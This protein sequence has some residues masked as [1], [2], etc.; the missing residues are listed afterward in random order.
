M[1]FKTITLCAL[2][3]LSF[4]PAA[5]SDRPYAYW[6]DEP[7]WT[8]ERTEAREGIKTAWAYLTSMRNNCWYFIL[9]SVIVDSIIMDPRLVDGG[10]MH[11]IEYFRD[12]YQTYDYYYRDAN[13]STI[14][15][16]E[17]VSANNKQPYSLNEYHYIAS[18]GLI[19]FNTL[20]YIEM[21]LW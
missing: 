9:D 12:G 17:R 15:V 20:K 19:R 4:V 6:M 5:A 1:N 2:L 7:K 8:E 18:D 13:G 11:R 16:L 14:P 10:E 21:V 3:F